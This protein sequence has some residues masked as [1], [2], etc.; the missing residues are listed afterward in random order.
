MGDAVNQDFAERYGPWAIVTGGSEGVGVSWARALTE[1]GVKVVLVARRP[2]PLEQTAGWLRERGAEVRTLALDVTATDVVEQLRTVTDDI[3]IGL[4]V[5][6]AG[7]VS[8]D[9]KWF[10]DEELSSIESVIAL[11]VNASARL[12][13][14]YGKPMRERGHGGIVIIS[15]LSGTAGQP[16][17]AAYSASKAFGQ[18]LCEALWNELKDHGVDVVSVPLGGTLTEKLKQS[19]LDIDMDA[20]PT[21]D[22][23]V[24][25]A[26][27][28]L[29]DGP[30]YVPNASN[31]KFFETVSRMPRRDAAEKM[32]RLAYRTHPIP[33]S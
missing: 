24:D 1:R 29:D 15:S 10:L 21:A 25:E 13:Y 5:H 4:L 32:A 17:E 22:E 14:A 28:H 11:N 27:E 9:Q 19:N 18:V 8:R 7:A 23:I 16:L 31:R 26:I 33:A 3:E 12:A 20:I 6:N 2:D 30:V